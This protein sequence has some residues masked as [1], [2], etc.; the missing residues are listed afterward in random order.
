MTWF[1]F[2]A[3]AALALA[4]GGCASMQVA[5]YA[6]RGA[7]LAAHRT[8]G[9]AAVE[10]LRTG[11]PRL[12]NNEIFHQRV[13]EAVDRAMAARGYEQGA[14]PDLLLHYHASVTQRI[15]VSQLDQ[16]YGGC[17]A[18]DCG[19][20]VYDRGTLVID[21]V[22]ART[23]RLLWRGWAEDAV[24]RVIDDQDWL[25]EKIDEAVRRILDRLPRRP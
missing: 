6:E 19:P 15:D 5:S 9:W 4:A 8:Y 3:A 16:R 7:N 1:R 13:Q 20:R 18:G 2:A 10:E 22:D 25:E 12:D 11:D 14:P 17:E 21:L 23:N 24:D